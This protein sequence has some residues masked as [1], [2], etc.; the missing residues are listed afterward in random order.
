MAIGESF[1]KVKELDGQEQKSISQPF[2]EI[3]KSVKSQAE[4]MEEKLIMQVREHKSAAESAFNAYSRR[5][6][7]V[8]RIYELQ[9]L[10]DKHQY[11]LLRQGESKEDEQ[12]LD[13]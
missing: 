5:K 13:E 3:S 1:T 12:K 4:K 2:E 11:F 8:S 7:I 9:N 10:V 6:A